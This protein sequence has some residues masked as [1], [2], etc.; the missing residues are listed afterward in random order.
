[1]CHFYGGGGDGVKHGDLD[2]SL[3]DAPRTLDV[4]MASRDKGGAGFTC[5]TCHT[6][7]GHRLSGSRFAMTASDPKGPAMRGA[8]E[9]RNAASCA[10]CHGDAPHAA[11]LL[12]AGLLN[13]HGRRLAC[14]SCHVP[15]V[16]RG[17]VATRMSWDWSTAGR[18]SPDGKPF[19]AKD[20][21][22]DV[23]YDSRKGDFEPA[24]NVV[25]EYRWFDGTVRYTLQDDPI[26]PDEVVRINRFDGGP[27][28]PASRIWPVKRFTGRQPYDVVHRRMLALH[29]AGAD[30]DAFWTSFDWDRALRAGA[31]ASGAEYSGR[32]GFVRTE[33]LWPITH[34]V[35][36]RAQSVKCGHCHAAG[37]RMDGVPGLY[38]PGRDAHPWIDRLGWLAV[39]GALAGVLAHGGA[40]LLVRRRSR[41]GRPRG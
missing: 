7:D 9:G 21:R 25:P 31:E 11:R 6:S 10:S 16:A 5:A 8:D 26:D 41:P 20:A 35:A 36:P 13:R 22:G 27:D 19:V 29:T 28:D 32:H 15:A 1:M 17:G 37:G 33:M 14:Q 34:M 2:S 24:R 30:E 38:L 3:V 12:D 4:H 40:R 39:A 23:T 18:L